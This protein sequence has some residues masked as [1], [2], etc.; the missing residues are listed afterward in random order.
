MRVKIGDKIYDTEI[1]PIMLIFES[2]LE[3]DKVGSNL[4]NME[5]KEGV[6]KYCTYPNDNFS[7]EQIQE[8]MKL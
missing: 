7:V 3:K 1:E 2:D 8:F 5:F 6:R 4:I